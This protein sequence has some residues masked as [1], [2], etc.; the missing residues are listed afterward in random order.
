MNGIPQ[1]DLRKCRHRAISPRLAE[2][3]RFGVSLRS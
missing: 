2:T 1:I 3:F